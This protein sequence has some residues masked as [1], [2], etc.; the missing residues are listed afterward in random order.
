MVGSSLISRP[1]VSL[2][3]RNRLTPSSARALSLVRATT[4]STSAR[5]ASGTNSLVPESTN[6]PSAA[7]A[8]VVTPAASQRALGSVHASVAFASPVAILVSH[9]SFCAAEPASRMASPP[10]IV[11][12]K[13]GPGMTTRPISSISTVR[14]TK[15]S[16]APPY[17]SG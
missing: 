8:V 13:N 11:V 7:R 2:L 17:C 16:P 12:E 10:R 1:G 5:W 14:S 4:T 15:P 6:P 3:T 9:S